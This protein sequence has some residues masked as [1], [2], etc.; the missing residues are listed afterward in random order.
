M[1]LRHVFL[2]AGLFSATALADVSEEL[3]WSF[4]L[5][6]GGRIVLE[7][8][9]G[10]VEVTGGDGKQVEIIAV[11][12][13]GSQEYLDGIEIEIEHSAD[14]I[15]IETR[16]P[17]SGI[18][19]MFS[20]GG[21]GSGS[22]HYT[23]KV[24]AGA[25]LDGV[26]S[27]NGDVSI[28]GVDG[29][30]R[31]GTVNGAVTVS[32]IASDANLE[33]VNGSVNASFRR[34]GGQQKANCESVNGKVTVTLP[35]DTSAS[36]TAETINGGI[37]GDDFGLK[38]NKGFIGRDLEGEIGDGSARLSLDTVNGAIKIRRQ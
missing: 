7:N 6:D 13:A 17:D 1:Q 34:L 22:V 14:T 32:D 12:R 28:A 3:T 36:V 25:N 30:I 4:E 5:A 20:W 9:N 24:P 18:K 15:R 38:V 31:A 8:I 2:L 35:A 26:E 10:D 37:N 29:V 19:R 33:T 11:K 27:V 16:H 23:L 21:D